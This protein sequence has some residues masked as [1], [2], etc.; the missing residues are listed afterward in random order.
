MTWV[1]ETIRDFG[2]SI[3][4][5]ELMLNERGILDLD[6]P[7]EARLRIAHLAH[8]P[9]PEVVLSRSETR[10]YPTSAMLAELLKLND[11]RNSSEWPIQTAISDH[12]L[13]ISVRIPE[14]SFVVNAME[15]AL[16]S[17]Q[18]IHVNIR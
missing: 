18:K 10:F 2:I 13:C 14:R 15:Q 8:L 9:V 4:L 5:P 7:N 16:S 1:N 17:L 6:L 12:E 3:G 11:F